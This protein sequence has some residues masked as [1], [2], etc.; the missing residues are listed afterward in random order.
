MAR[1]ICISDMHYS[2]EEEMYNDDNGIRL[3]HSVGI[4]SINILLSAIKEISPI[5]LIAF[6]GDII[7]G[8]DSDIEKENAIQNFKDFIERVCSI[9]KLFGDTCSDPRNRILFVPGNHDMNRNSGE[10]LSS[11]SYLFNSYLSTERKPDIAHPFAPIFVFDEL[12]LIVA[13]ISTAQNNNA[14]NENIERVLEIVSALP[15]EYSN[16]KREVTQKLEHYNIYDIP[17]VTSE[18]VEKFISNSR[19][20]NKTN[21]YYDYK[22]IMITHHP[23]LEGVEQ[24]PVLKKYGKTVGGYRF[25]KNAEEFGY[26]LFIHGHLHNQSCVEIIDHLTGNK[27]S[28]VQLGLPQMRVDQ[29]GCGCVLI[30]IDDTNR[31][32]CSLLKLDS[33]AWRFKQVPILTPNHNVIMEY[34]GDKILVDSEIAEIIKDNII[35]KNGD[36][37][38]IEAASYDCSLGYEYKKA[39]GKFCNWNDEQLQMITVNDGPGGIWLAPGETALIFTYE[40][41]NIP[42]DMVVHASP[43]SSWLRRGIRF[44]ISYFVDPGFKGKFSIPV[45]NES[46]KSV[47][48]NAQNPIISLE[49][50]RLANSSEHG[51][52]ERHLEHSNRK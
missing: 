49:F 28:I 23:L 35:V 19:D 20:I 33:I 1:I 12:K 26:S 46:S 51:W 24:G 45:T 48:I 17:S 15:E 16:Q 3:P 21:K 40:E 39:K 27:N 47:C 31:F 30:D 4:N 34:S 44:D 9:E 50:V 43:I 18:T 14:K 2:V 22:R 5:D 11:M 6:C 36:L 42:K 52:S 29:E 7:T 25:M 32:S 8:K 37:N 13:T 10:L 41:F 38:N